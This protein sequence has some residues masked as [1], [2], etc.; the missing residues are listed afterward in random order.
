VRIISGYHKGRRLNPGK[1]FKARPTTDFAKENLFNV[2][3]NYFDFENL[4]VLDLFSGTG[5]IAYE[6][7]SRGSRQVDAV[8][9]NAK[10]HAFIRKTAG[11]LGLKNLRPIR[12]D[13][14]QFLKHTQGEYDMIFADP[15]YD[16]KE[17]DQ[18]PDLVFGHNLLKAGGWFIME[19][20]KDHDFSRHQYFRELR[21]YGSVHFSIFENSV[22]V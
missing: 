21:R 11:E 14:F 3:S 4:T 8:E 15:P 19:H 5:S 22:T 16:L 7:S 17:L 9:V 2:L 18:V 6:F 10:Y 1:S 12:A 20:G 13:V